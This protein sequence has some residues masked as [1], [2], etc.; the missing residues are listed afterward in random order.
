MYFVFRDDTFYSNNVALKE[1]TIVANSKN[2][3]RLL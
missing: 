3:M 1:N 2:N